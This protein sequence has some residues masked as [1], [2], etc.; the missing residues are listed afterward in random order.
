MHSFESQL[1]A[2][3][4]AHDWQSVTAAVAVSGG[5]DSVALL[6]GLSALHPAA[7]ERL[8]VLHFN[9]KLR[10]EAAEVDAAFV[11]NLAKDVGLRCL[12]GQ[13]EPG[14]LEARGD[15]LEAAA[16]EARYRFFI[17]ACNQCGARYLFTAHTADDQA[18]TVLH[19][20][21]RGTGIDGLAGIL[22]TRVLSPLTTLVRPLI[23][24]CRSEIEDYLHTTSQSYNEDETNRQLHF[25][26]N[27]LR[28]DLLPKLA[29]EYNAEVHGALR[30]LADLASEATEC[31]DLLVDQLAA[32]ALTSANG[33]VRLTTDY[34]RNAP[35]YLVRQLFIRIWQQQAWPLQAM[36][37]EKWHQLAAL[38]QGNNDS[39]LNLPGAVRAKKQGEQLVLTRPAGVL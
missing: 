13:A 26:R 14:A 30:R 29:E 1:N 17:Q 24:T 37:Y 7:A 3:L 32:D 38:T 4:A 31:I 2:Q 33:E 23:T 19:R 12:I 39:N 6:R 9:H 28:H 34:L 10:G 16:R 15:S 22:S 11:E 27:R 20:I 5:A 35:P 21:L 36:T 18:E 8:V 25:T